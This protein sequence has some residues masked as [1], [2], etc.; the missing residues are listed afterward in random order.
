M[1]D[2]S[3]AVRK[4]RAYSHDITESDMKP[5]NML[6][7][8]LT[9]IAVS[10]FSFMA[11]ANTVRKP[12]VAGQFYAG[13]PETLSAG[14]RAMLE[15]ALP[16]AGKRPS[17]L[18]VPHA[19]YIYSGQIAAD[20]FKQASGHAYDVVVILGTN[21]TKGG[22]EKVAVYKGAGFETPLGVAQIDTELAATLVK[23][24][25][26]IE[27]ENSLHKREHSIEVQIPF[28]QTL[29]PDA[30]ILPAVI[31]SA[32]PGLCVRFGEVV[33]DVVKSRHALIVASSDLS[34][35]PDADGADRVDR[36]T[37]KAVSSMDI[38][39]IGSALKSPVGQVSGLST[40]ACGAG[41]I[42][43]VTTAATALGAGFAQLISYANSG[44]TVIGN[45]SRVVGYGAMG[46]YK[47]SPAI[48]PE[49]GSQPESGATHNMKLTS[50]DK[51]ALL[52]FARKT[53][54][55]MLA[56]Q[57]APLARGFPPHLWNRQGAF[58]T[59][60]KDHELRGCI[61]HMAE[62]TPL[63]QVVGKMA[64][65]AAFN[66]RRF[67][68]LN[69]DELSGIEIEISVLTPF[70]E[71]DSYEAIRIGI[72]GTVIKKDGRSA[73]FLPQVAPEQGWNRSEMLSHLCRKAGLSSDSWK[74]DM[75]FFTFQAIVFSESDFR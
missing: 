51:K 12:S 45:S 14:I 1:G 54:E 36:A 27:F 7:I 49:L 18:I 34:H 24:A 74:R 11:C 22:Y 44:D 58:V 64:V 10:A 70:R 75:R 15:N 25:D 59:L 53:V 43:T 6:T 9:G 48:E 65:Q 42:M 41:P 5:I 30:G 61:G 60:K 23:S 8:L 46:F 38:D 57:T 17:A 39:T 4:S 37:L 21:H 55:Q 40:A 31:G 66:D 29:F 47:Q 50:Q 3:T 20:A 63:C 56:T 52:A 2:V 19:G 35:Y 73:V 72:D 32:D 26:F 67:S 16:A 71:V 28:I 62:D 13:D 33:A 68:P 69:P